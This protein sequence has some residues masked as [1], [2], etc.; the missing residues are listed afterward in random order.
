MGFLSKR[1]LRRLASRAKGLLLGR[2]DHQHPFDVQHGTDT[3]GVIA[4]ASLGAGGE[5]DQHITAYAGVPPSRMLAALEI[6]TQQIGDRPVSDFAFFD[7]G[8]GKGR[9]LLLGSQL[10]FRSALGVELDADLAKIAQRNAALWTSAG[11]AACAIRAEQGDATKVLYGEGPRLVFLYNPFGP[12]V[13]RI[14]LNALSAMGGETYIIYQNEY[15]A[16]PLQGD[17][18]LEQ[19]FRNSL[20][21]SDEDAV[22][23]PVASPEDIT[24]IYRMRQPSL[25]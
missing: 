6:W 1:K 8:C 4:G 20:P 18:R 22:A 14:V 5:S 7:L 23:D 10:P 21:M 13:M 19:L 25:R 11:K 12:P 15:D 17:E 3:S 2:K 16:T 24:G 9:S